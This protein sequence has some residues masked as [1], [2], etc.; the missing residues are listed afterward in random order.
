M[1]NFLRKLIPGTE[2]D[3]ENEE[4]ID[5]R[6]EDKALDGGKGYDDI[7]KRGDEKWQNQ[8]QKR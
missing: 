7:I 6:I 8:P 2:P 5:T 4:F 3:I 1:L